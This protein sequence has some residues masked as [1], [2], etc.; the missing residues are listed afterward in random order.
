MSEPKITIEDRQNNTV[1]WARF[2]VMWRSE[3]RERLG[4][5]YNDV[6]CDNDDKQIAVMKENEV[7]SMSGEKLGK[8][9]ETVST[10]ESGLK[11][12]SNSLI[13]NDQLVA[14]SQGDNLACLA[15]IIF[16][17]KELYAVNN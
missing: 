1:A 6:I 12:S 3:P 10:T 7:F 11:I 15:A 14:T 17:G 5:F 8:I 4:S 13:V 2:G 16:L 9:N